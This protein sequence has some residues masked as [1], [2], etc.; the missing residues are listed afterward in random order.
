MFLKCWRII[1]KDFLTKVAGEDTNHRGSQPEVFGKADIVK[2]FV[3][4]TEKHLCQ[5]LF[6]TLFRMGEVKKDPL[7]VFSRVT[8]TNVES[9]PK[10]FL[11][12]FPHWSKISRPYLVPVQSYW[13]WTKTTL[14]KKCSFFWSNPYNWGY[15]FLHRNARVAKLRSLLQYNLSHVI[16]SHWWS[17]RHKLWRHNLYFKTLLF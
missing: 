2:N 12:L 17:H 9:S 11:V 5:S 16:K 6:L 4:F 15:S 3:R 10:N 8:P 1:Q 13:T 14:Q 7:P